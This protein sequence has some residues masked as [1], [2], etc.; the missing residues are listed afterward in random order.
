METKTYIRIILLKHHSIKLHKY[1]K[2]NKAQKMYT[3]LFEELK[4][5][6]HIFLAMIK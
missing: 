6:I 3:I 2:I 4:S 5:I 1:L